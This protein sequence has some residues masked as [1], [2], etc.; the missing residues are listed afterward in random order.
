MLPGEVTQ[1]EWHQSFSLAEIYKFETIPALNNN[2]KFF[3]HMS[4]KVIKSEKSLEG[5]KKKRKVKRKRMEKSNCK[6]VTRM[7]A[8][9]VFNEAT[10]VL[11]L[12]WSVIFFLMS[13]H[14]KEAEY[15]FQFEYLVVDVL[16]S[17]GFFP[18][19]TCSFSKRGKDWVY[20][21][22]TEAT[23]M[24]KADWVQA[25]F[26]P[27]CGM[28][29]SCTAPHIKS[30][31]A[32]HFSLIENQINAPGLRDAFEIYEPGW[33]EVQ[34]HHQG[35]L[36]AQIPSILPHYPSLSVTPLDTI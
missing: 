16:N 10:I 32:S 11:F 17:R 23:L 26:K 21:L 9:S 6:S 30:I 3:L 34:D 28:F 13:C 5:K 15:D 12:I 24:M 20:C 35:M 22:L 7:F 2:L 8:I 18:G 29:V 25:I 19:S 31:F 4:E 27:S 14:T 33:L 1:A 36:T